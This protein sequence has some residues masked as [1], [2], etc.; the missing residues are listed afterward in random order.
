MADILDLIKSR[1]TVKEF[2]PK[3]VSWENISRVLDA[4]RHAPSCG[5]IQNWK[6]VV[7]M[8]PEQKQHL[9]ELA[10]EQ[11]EIVQAAVLIVVCA[12]PQKAERYYGEKGEQLYSI[13]NCAAAIQNMLLEA[14]S[15]GLAAR[16]VGAFDEDSVRSVI[17]APA[18]IK[19]QAIIA[20]GYAKEVPPKP[21]KYPLESLVYFGGWRNKLKDPA[22][23][24]NDIAT[25][26]ARKAQTGKE[27]VLK[28]M[29]RF[30]E[31][32]KEIISKNE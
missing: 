18:E 4:A 31:R 11:Y 30:G 22:K 28:G 12:E 23:Y 32:T 7:V 5:N 25:I 19:I 29:E 16:W 6:F 13:Q 17:T 27:M 20:L 2:I 15:L 1:R 10:Y 3:F 8:K 14:H 24:M 26:L 9:A 21:P